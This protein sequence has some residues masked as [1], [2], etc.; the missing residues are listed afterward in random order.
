M[1]LDGR[2]LKSRGEFARLQSPFLSPFSSILSRWIISGALSSRIRT[3][4]EEHAHFEELQ[5]LI[6]PF[7][8]QQETQYNPGAYTSAFS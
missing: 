3:R 2:A 5:E 1:A 7:G 8:L 4:R 6:E